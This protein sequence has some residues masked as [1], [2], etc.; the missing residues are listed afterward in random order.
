MCSWGK[1]YYLYSIAKT[2]CNVSHLPRPKPKMH[3]NY[4]SMFKKKRTKT[5]CICQFLMQLHCTLITTKKHYQ[6]W[7]Y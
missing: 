2:N 4:T 1:F 7:C 6:L 5:N 3:F